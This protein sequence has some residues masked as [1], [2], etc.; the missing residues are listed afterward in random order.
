MDN[1]SGLIQEHSPPGLRS[2]VYTV[3]GGILVNDTPGDVDGDFIGMAVADHSTLEIAPTALS[4]LGIDSALYGMSAAPLVDPG[5][6]FA[7]VVV[8][9]ADGFGWNIFTGLEGREEIANFS[10]IINI[11]HAITACPSK[12]NVAVAMMLTGKPPAENGVFERNARILKTGSILDIAESHGKTTTFIEGDIRFLDMNMSLTMDGNGDGLI[13]DD[14]K[15]KTLRN[16]DHSLVVVHFHG[17][18][19][20]G[21]SHGIFSYEHIEAVERVNGYVGEIRR[22]LENSSWSDA[23][24]DSCSTLFMVVADHGMHNAAGDEMATVMSRGREGNPGS[25]TGT[26]GD[27]R[28]EDMYSF[29]AWERIPGGGGR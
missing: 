19:D 13:D 25:G 27:F 4:A 18:D 5:A 2:Y 9:I 22:E 1:V 11:S 26:H 6:R 20:A 16:L 12:T 15:E 10:S 17:I 21:H 14:I 3:G 8:I 29:L 7:R 24:N 28:H 23:E